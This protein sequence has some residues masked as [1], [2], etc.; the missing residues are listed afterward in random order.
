MTE[1]ITAI[2]P[3]CAQA[4]N[5]PVHVAGDIP[6]PPVHIATGREEC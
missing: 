6:K 1:R 5:Q 4:L 3:R 2:C